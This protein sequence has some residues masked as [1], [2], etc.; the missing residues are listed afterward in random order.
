MHLPECVLVE[1][2]SFLNHL[3]DTSG[4]VAT[5]PS[6]SQRIRKVI[7]SGPVIGAC[8]PTSFGVY[9]ARHV[10]MRNQPFPLMLRVP[11]RPVAEAPHLAHRDPT[12]GLVSE[13]PV[14]VGGHHAP[15]GD[16]PR[17]NRFPKSLDRASAIDSQQRS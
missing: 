9:E 14:H 4:P 3:P 7:W 1:R 16:S 10:L 12:H 5:R 8:R 15:R 11:A 2:I 6:A 17:P 13:M